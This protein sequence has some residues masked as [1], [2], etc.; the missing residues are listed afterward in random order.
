MINNVSSSTSGHGHS[1]FLSK[2]FLA[3]SF[4]NRFSMNAYIK[5]RLFFIKYH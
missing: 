4:M 1:G 2:L 5:K 3:H